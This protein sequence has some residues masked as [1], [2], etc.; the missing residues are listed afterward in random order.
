MD[1]NN[2]GIEDKVETITDYVIVFILL[3][4]AIY[5]F[6]FAK[7]F[8]FSGFMKL[9]YLSVALSGGRTAFISAFKKLKG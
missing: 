6:F 1:K 9:V 5:G 3:L 7:A 4:S 8:N 2:N